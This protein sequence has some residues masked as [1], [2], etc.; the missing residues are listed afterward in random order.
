MRYTP[1]YIDLQIGSPCGGADNRS[2]NRNGFLL[3]F[4][5]TVVSSHID[6]IIDLSFHFI[7]FIL[8][9]YLIIK[10]V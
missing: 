3:E 6:P 1:Y 7:F 5:Y 10:S 2:F 9:Y 4:Y 8:K